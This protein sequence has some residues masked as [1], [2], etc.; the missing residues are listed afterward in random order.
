[1]EVSGD[2]HAEGIDKVLGKRIKESA[3]NSKNRRKHF[4]SPKL[5]NCFKDEIFLI[6]R[7]EYTSFI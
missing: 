5:L 3:A 7:L 4:C 6:S 2:T 1:M